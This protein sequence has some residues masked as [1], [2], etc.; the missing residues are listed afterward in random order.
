MSTTTTAPPRRLPRNTVLP[1]AGVSF[2]QQDVRSM[3]VGDDVILR[4]DTANTRD[5]TAVTVESS[6]GRLLGYVPK[7]SDLNVRLAGAQPGG[8]WSAVVI[9][10]LDRETCGLRIKLGELIGQSDPRFA[11]SLPGLRHRDDGFP[12]PTSPPPTSLDQG[13][14]APEAPHE[15]LVRTRTGRVLGKLAEVSG[16]RVRVTTREGV[17]AYPA[18]VVVIDD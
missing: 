12:D 14:A 13:E 10:V 18:A 9:E 3:H 6:D 2:R 7:A 8:V 1:V 16:T 11:A 4:H 5:P 17:V 15:R